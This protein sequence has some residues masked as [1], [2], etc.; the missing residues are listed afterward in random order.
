MP[1]GLAVYFIEFPQLQVKRSKNVW[2]FNLIQFYLYNALI[3]VYIE[4]V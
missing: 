4:D 1:C 2:L 3:N